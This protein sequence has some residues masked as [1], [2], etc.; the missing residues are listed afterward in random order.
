MVK[1]VLQAEEERERRE[2]V[3]SSMWACIDSDDE[4]QH[5]EQASQDDD[6]EELEAGTDSDIQ[7]MMMVTSLRLAPTV[8]FSWPIKKILTGQSALI[9]CQHSKGMRLSS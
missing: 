4:R 8:T 1:E 7:L 2:A 9:Q 5:G 3:D 6:G